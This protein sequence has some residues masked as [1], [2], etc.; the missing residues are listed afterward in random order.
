M[1]G[2]YKCQPRNL[3]ADKVSFKIRKNNKILRSNKVNKVT[4]DRLMP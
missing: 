3:Y 2:Q 4:V 1:L